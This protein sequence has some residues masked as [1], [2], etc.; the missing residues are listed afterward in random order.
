MAHELERY[1]EAAMRSKLHFEVS[2]GGFL[3]TNSDAI[4][5]YLANHAG[6]LSANALKTRTLSYATSKTLG[7]LDLAN[8]AWHTAIVSWV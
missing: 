3:P 7:R 2:W 1:I 5:R 8:E 6:A 4:A